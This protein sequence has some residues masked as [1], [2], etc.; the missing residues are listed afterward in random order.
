[1]CLERDQE[2]VTEACR[3]SRCCCEAVTLIEIIRLL[4]VLEES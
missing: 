3:T 1:M 2:Q 4:G